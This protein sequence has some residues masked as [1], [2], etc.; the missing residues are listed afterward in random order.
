M[1]EKLRI[2]NFEFTDAAEYAAAKREA[3]AVEYIR[4]KTDVTNPEIA[5]KVYNK[6]L[7]RKSF[8]TV[9]GTAFLQELY[10]KA[11]ESGSE[12]QAYVTPEEEKQNRSREREKKAVTD[13]KD[14]LTARLRR[15]YIVIAG[16]V[17][18]VIILFS[19]GVY[20]GMFTDTGSEIELQDKYSAWAEELEAREREVTERENALKNPAD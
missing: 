20:R 16:L 19:V 11:L 5:L 8:V 17:I 4:A 9:V 6:L 10:E 14:K 12:V 3:D 18:L 1:E 15:C 2:G 7:E 13:V